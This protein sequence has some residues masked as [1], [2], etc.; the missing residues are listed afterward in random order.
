MVAKHDSEAVWIKNRVPKGRK[1][2]VPQVCVQVTP[3]PDYW[4]PLWDNIQSSYVGHARHC[5][6]PF[7]RT[8]SW[9]YGPWKAL[10]ILSPTCQAQQ[11]NATFSSCRC[12]KWKGWIWTR[13]PWPWKPLSHP[14]H[15]TACSGQTRASSKEHGVDMTGHTTTDWNNLAFLVYKAPS[16]VFPYLILT[17]AWQ[18]D[19]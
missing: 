1:V 10:T 7:P 15:H 8:D 2:T 3:D 14:S 4:V 19:Y 18:V 9:K 11:G 12:Q 6:S 5:S 13:Y 16:S 17:T